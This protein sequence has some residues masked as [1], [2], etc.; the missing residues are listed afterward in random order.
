[1]VKTR[2]S[3]QPELAREPSPGSCPTTTGEGCEND[4]EQL[5]VPVQRS[6]KTKKQDNVADTIKLVNQAI[7]N[8]PTVKMIDFMREE[9]DKCREHETKLLQM[10]CQTFSSSAQQPSPPQEYGY[11]TRTHV[12]S[13]SSQYDS[14]APHLFGNSWGTFVSQGY[15]INLHVLRPASP[16]TYQ[17]CNSS[18]HHF[19]CQVKA[20]TQMI[21]LVVAHTKHEKVL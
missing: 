20:Q 14:F 11:P 13:P 9:M 10:L 12:L 19:P 5:F 2:D 7:E 16:A 15:Q 18:Q 3:C 17:P 6:R 1:M 4:E 8:D 21:V